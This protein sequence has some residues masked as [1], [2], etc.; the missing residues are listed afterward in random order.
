MRK[1]FAPQT[2]MFGPDDAFHEIEDL[3]VAAEVGEGLRDPVG[4]VQQDALALLGGQRVD[5]LDHPLARREFVRREHG[6]GE[7]DAVVAVGLD[8]G[9][10]ERCGHL[11]V[12]RSLAVP[13]PSAR[14]GSQLPDPPLQGR[15]AGAQ[16][17]TG[18]VSPL[19]VS[20][21]GDA[22]APHSPAFGRPSPAGEGSRADMAEALAHTEEPS[23]KG[24]GGGRHPCTTSARFPA[25][26][27]SRPPPARRLAGR[28]GPSGIPAA[29]PSPTNQPRRRRWAAGGRISWSPRQPH[30]AGSW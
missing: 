19:G 17:L 9:G 22:P 5:A 10:G 11:S 27:S 12:S 13:V 6:V 26:T 20:M 8:L 14:M 23:Q 30:R 29:P 2:R 28:P 21:H 7:Q 4:L 24:D 16:R 18:G 15:V 25:P 3:R 1:K